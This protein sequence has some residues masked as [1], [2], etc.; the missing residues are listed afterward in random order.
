MRIK[1]KRFLG[2]FFSLALVLGLMP[3]M[4]LTAHADTTYN[5]WVGG[6]Q[7]TS[8]NATDTTA[9]P[10]W[11]YDAGTNTL[12]LNSY[13]YSGEGHTEYVSEDD[14]YYTG[15]IFARVPL[16][17]NQKGENSV[18][19]ANK[20]GIAYFDNLEITGN[21][22]LSVSGEY[23]IETSGNNVTISGGTVVASGGY[24]GIYSYGTVTVNGGSLTAV[25]E[26]IGIY[27]DAVVSLGT[28]T[29]VKAGAD[30]ASAAD[31]IDTSAWAQR[32]E[33]PQ[34][35]VR[36]TTASFHT[37]SFTYSASG[38]I[39]TATC[40]ADGCELP[41]STE[42]GLDHVAKLSL[43]AP[44]LTTYGGT[45]DATATLDGVADFNT[46]T[47]KT[48]ATTD[49]KYVDRDGTTY[50]ESATAP[51]DAG[52]YTAKITVEGMTASLNYEIAEAD[53]TANSDE[54]GNA[55]FYSGL[56]ITQKKGKI[57]VSWDKTEGVSKY[58][59]FITY[60][61]KDYPKKAVK[62]TTNNSVTVKKINGRKIDFTKNIRMYV[63]AFDNN[64][65]S[66]GKSINRVKNKKYV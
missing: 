23:G 44:T 64:G 51:I 4:S 20:A 59:L 15:G 55:D 50:A 61:G 47:G 11:S 45:G 27:G 26:T 8:A 12:T 30:E 32:F 31:I 66:V 60:C 19:C 1:M 18:A 2:I 24:S 56:K 33:H 41:P 28:G 35:W 63:E 53:S 9:H 5:L 13:S 46:A 6:M 42:G 36:I 49:I 17:I 21:G 48:I 7:V 14:A 65:A 57:K 22:S 10:A 37:H 34:K 3:G 16:I 43:V 58:G 40:T 29:A 25:G 39:I 54:S 62:T 38:A 52:K